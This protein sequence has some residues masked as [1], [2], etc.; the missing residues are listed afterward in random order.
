M[1]CGGF[2]RP[3]ASSQELTQRLLGLGLDAQGGNDLVWAIRGAPEASHWDEGRVV[4][5][6]KTYLNSLDRPLP[7]PPA[8]RIKP[9]HRANLEA[10]DKP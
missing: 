7:P 9:R 5:Q 2:Q 6:P 4:Q 1:L 10:V 8:A 3:E